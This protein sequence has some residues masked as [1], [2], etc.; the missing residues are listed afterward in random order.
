MLRKGETIMKKSKYNI[1]HLYKNS[2]IIYNTLS[3]SVIR[4]DAPHSRMYNNPNAWSTDENFILNMKRGNFIVPDE[5]DEL[6]LILNTSNSSR[7]K[8]NIG[9]YTIAPT[10]E[11]NFCCPYCFEPSHK[12]I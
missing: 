11:C 9:A 5:V 7:K 2:L 1:E 12:K 10:L 8:S 6:N 3:G 4:L